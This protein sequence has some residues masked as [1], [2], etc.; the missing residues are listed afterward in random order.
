M[1]KTAFGTAIG[2][3]F[4]ALTVGC[5][6]ALAQ[7]KWRDSSGIVHYSD[8]P[9]PAGTPAQAIL[10]DNKN[11]I[12][13]STK[14]ITGQQTDGSDSGRTDAPDGAAQASPAGSP[15]K[16]AEAPPAPDDKKDLAKEDSSSVPDWKLKA[17]QMQKRRKQLATEQARQEKA[18]AQRAELERAC[19]TMRSELR[20]LESGM[21]VFSVDKDGERQVLEEERRAAR[22]SELENNLRVHCSPG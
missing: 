16:P 2:L 13:A 7:W 5:R 1:T 18:E 9:P 19:E 11:S 4:I 10:W 20:T 21:R 6:P 8:L 17:D 15:P 12:P 22:I 14:G 3:I